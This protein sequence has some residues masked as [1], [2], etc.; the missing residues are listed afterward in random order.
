MTFPEKIYY[1]AIMDE[2]KAEMHSFAFPK[3]GP[4][5]LV[6]KM[7]IC[8][9]CT[10][11]YQQF[12]GMRKKK[13]PMA[14]GHECSGIIVWKGEKV[15]SFFEV[16][17]Q[18][19]NYINS[20]GVCYECRTG[21]ES[22][23]AVHDH[24]D[25]S[26]EDGFYGR[27]IGGR[28]FANYMVVDQR[29][30]VPVA[31]DIEPACA[32]FLEPFSAALHAQRKAH[33]KPGEDLVVIGGGTMGLVNAQVGHALGA[34]VIVTELDPFKLERAR[35]MGICDVIDAK[36]EDPIARVNELTGGKG[37]DIA[38][39]T[40][41]LSAAYQQAY[42]VLRRTSGRIVLYSA[43]YP[44]P[45]LPDDLKDANKIHYRKIDVVGTIGADGIDCADAARM[46]SNRLVRP[47]YILQQKE[48]IPLRDIQKA[49]E[50][51]CAGTYRISVDLQGI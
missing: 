7:N 14:A 15:S 10:N 27:P 44:T 29:R 37:A 32:A 45:E 39:P 38:I 23:C 18:V 34:R 40:I 42:N 46:I 25:G 43:G 3:P 20:C 31:N 35:S 13:T 48:A 24:F 9:I 21:H 19:S 4:S 33:I 12:N 28:G 26:Y 51:A 6:I 8:N 41:A 22:D 5:D 2:G 1:G 17:M 16:G 11:D 30:V 36:N 50:L 49:Y 47:E